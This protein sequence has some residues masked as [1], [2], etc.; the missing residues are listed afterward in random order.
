MLTSSDFKRRV[1]GPTFSSLFLLVEPFI[2]SELKICMR[3]FDTRLLF[4]F[5]WLSYLSSLNLLSTLHYQSIALTQK[6]LLGWEMDEALA[7]L[8]LG[9]LSSREN[10]MDKEMLKG[11][12]NPA[13]SKLNFLPEGISFVF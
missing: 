13:K 1:T 4:F 3:L 10:C 6:G 2:S 5:P 11:I 8:R 12:Q 7:K 9:L